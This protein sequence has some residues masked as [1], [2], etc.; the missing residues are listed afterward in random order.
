MREVSGPGVGNSTY[1]A[2]SRVRKIKDPTEPSSSFNKKNTSYAT[3]IRRAANQLIQR[4]VQSNAATGGG[5]VVS[6]ASRA[7][8]AKSPGAN[9]LE[10]LAKE[11]ANRNLCDF[12]GYR[13]PGTHWTMALA[14][15]GETNCHVS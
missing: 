8:S 4:G 11:S 14:A 1:V 3:M 7:L 15:A 10:L 12:E 5:A 6:L 9:P 13:E 2:T